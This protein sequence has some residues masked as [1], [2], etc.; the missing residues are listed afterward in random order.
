MSAGPIVALASG[1]IASRLILTTGMNRLT[2]EEKGR[3]VEALTPLHTW[4][5]VALV[6]II[7]GSMYSPWILV[8]GLPLYLVA[9]VAGTWM[10]LSNLSLSPS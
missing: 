1:A 6:A 7:A 9:L 5:Y 8:L 4:S 3:I 2:V 10:K